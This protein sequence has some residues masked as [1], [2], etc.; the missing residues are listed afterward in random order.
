MPGFLGYENG[1][2][3]L[4]PWIS[5]V[6]GCH[7]DGIAM[8]YQDSPNFS[9]KEICQFVVNVI[10]CQLKTGER[11]WYIIRC[12]LDLGDGVMIWYLEADMSERPRGT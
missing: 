3:G 6:Q 8:F 7:D 2:R 11:R 12:Y 10:T 1:G 9:V 4:H 5:R